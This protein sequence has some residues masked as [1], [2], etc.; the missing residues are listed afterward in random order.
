[1]ARNLN[2]NRFN[3]TTVRKA[4]RPGALQSAAGGVRWGNQ[5]GK[6][7]WTYNIGRNV[8]LSA[9]NKIQTP[10]R[11]QSGGRQLTNANTSL[12]GRSKL[13]KGDSGE[14]KKKKDSNEPSGKT[15]TPPSAGWRKKESKRLHR[16]AATS[17][18]NRTITK[19]TL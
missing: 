5:L 2:P 10:K 13:I 3:C 12:K 9:K 6:K 18:E 19:N 17:T 1:M 7:K 4:H 11:K 8:S 14:D 16:T 15:K